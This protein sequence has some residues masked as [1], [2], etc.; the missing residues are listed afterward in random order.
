LWDSAH[1]IPLEKR[2]PLMKLFQNI[3]YAENIIEKRI[4]KMM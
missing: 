4:Q 1:N 3:L 2:K